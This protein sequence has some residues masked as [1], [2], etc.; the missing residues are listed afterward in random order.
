MMLTGI[1]HVCINVGE[2]DTYYL[3]VFD[4]WGLEAGNQGSTSHI[5]PQTSRVHVPP[6]LQLRRL[7]G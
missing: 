7:T 4:V 6:T 3:E 5:A 2:I 1:G